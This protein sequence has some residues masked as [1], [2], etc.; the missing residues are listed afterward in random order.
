M[1]AT[2]NGSFK[3][4]ELQVRFRSSRL[5]APATIK[6]PADLHKF[7]LPL[8]K[9]QPRELLVSVA[10]DPAN[11][12]VGYEVVSQGTSDNAIAS[13]RE[14]FKA[15]LLTNANAFI[16]AH[17]HP[18]G[19]LEP[20]LEDRECAKRMAVAARLLDLKLLDFVIITEA[21]FYSFASSDPSGIETK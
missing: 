7:L 4:R 9:I 18:S 19:N 21:G 13:P 20:S 15:L 8:L 17:N 10:L 12:V 1:K 16:L 2:L 5:V 6:S 14:V 11:H 3:V